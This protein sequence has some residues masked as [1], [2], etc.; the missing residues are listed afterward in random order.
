MD[1]Y[2]NLIMVPKSAGEMQ[3]EDKT[4]QITY[5]KYEPQV[6]KFRVRY[7]TSNKD[8]YYAYNNVKWY[9]NPGEIDVESVRIFALGKMLYGITKILVFSDYWKIFF[10]TEKHERYFTTYHIS[11]LRIQKNVLAKV[12]IKTL[13][14]YY[15]EIARQFGFEVLGENRLVEQYE[16]C[17]FVSDDSVLSAFLKGYVDGQGNRMSQPIYYPFGCNG[18]QML[19]VERALRQK[20]SIIEGPPG[21]GKTQTIL[22]IVANI[23]CRGGNVAVVSNNNDAI[24]NVKEKL[25]KY[26]YGFMVAELGKQENRQE[27]IESGQSE[28]PP[29]TR[30]HYDIKKCGETIREVGMLQQYLRGMFELQNRLA[31]QKQFLTEVLREE[32]YFKEYYN[33]S[34]TEEQWSDKN[35]RSSS[36]KILKA[37]M[38]VEESKFNKKLTF[39][40][41]CRLRWLLKDKKELLKKSDMK[42]M[43]IELQALFYKK[44]KE[45]IRTEITKIESE[46]S[47]FQPEN[48]TKRLQELSEYI[49]KYNL[50]RK[51]SGKIRRPKFRIEDL[52]IRTKE[53]VQEY[54]VVLSTTFSVHNTLSP[55]FMYDYVIVDE[56][57]QV[58]LDTAVLAMAS[59][60]QLVIVGDRMQLPNV[61]PQEVKRQA[62][63]ISDKYQIPEK[64]RY[65]ENSLLSSAVKVFEQI[66]RTL[67]KEHYRCHPKIIGFCNQKF[68]NNQLI[69]MTKDMGEDDVL[70]AYVTAP[71]S[72]AREHLNQRQIDE[73]T[74]V[75]LPDLEKD[76]KNPD[77]GIVSPYRKQ[78][79]ALKLEA[80]PYEILTVHK[81][82]GREKDDIV[83]CTVDN[84]ISEFTDNPNMLNVAVSRAKKRLRIVISDSEK[85]DSTNIGEL[86]RYIRY[87]NFEVE[88]STLYSVFDLL[89]QCYSEKLVEFISKHSSVS[90]YNSENL[91]Y[92]LICDV[93]QQERFSDLKVACHFK[94]CMMFRDL[95]R[96]DEE[97]IKYVM[98]P[99]THVDFLIYS[100]IDKKP[101]LAVEV[102]GYEY[103]KEGTKQAERDRRKDEIMKKYE[104]PIIRFATNGSGEKEKL[105]EVL[106]SILI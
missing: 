57:S 66:E 9:K 96:L 99:N 18:S 23:V 78:V 1:V 67:L 100:G 7:K 56:A 2:K 25:Q 33:E 95:S 26:K 83:I 36:K 106:N 64:Y 81:F 53:F 89:Y 40:K 87:L 61:I 16:K 93:L 24:K 101:I 15:T 62:K 32:E 73:I 46:L 31:E 60:K 29:Y 45:E 54:P 37:W 74:K 76:S 103:H 52:R 51:Y 17:N 91:M 14:S 105:E 38:I 8:Y 86:I 70:K 102:D 27:F 68:Y 21:T 88:Q 13:M 39:I 12:E 4:E 43:V 97:E 41:K 20:V 5:C 79:E 49:F 92:W 22:N 84:E 90:E 65:E 42:G 44:K 19:A 28:Y 77:I 11:D 58:S 63:L 71:G 55:D 85:N 6:K 80:E 75:I 69:I 10:V 47:G 94:L 30:E 35:C 104:F 82:Q 3:W 98:N 50:V 59:A 34:N 72:H 48:A